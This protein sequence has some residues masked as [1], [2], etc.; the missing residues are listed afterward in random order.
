MAE[1]IGIISGAITF[2][3]VVAQIS[4]S[5]FQIKECWSQIRDAPEELQEL[6]AELEIYD[7]ILRE[8]EQSLSLGPLAN[9][10][11]TSAH[12][13]R[14]LEICKKAAE[15]LQVISNELAKDLSPSSRVRRSYS[16][17]KT[18][19]QKSKVEKY[20][21]KLSNSIRLLSLSQQCYSIALM[22]TQP[23]MG[24][25]IQVQENKSDIAAI[26]LLMISD[27]FQ[28]NKQEPGST[29]DVIDISSQKCTYLWRLGLPIWITSKVFEIQGKRA[30]GGWQWV[31]R[32]YDFLSRGHPVF[33][34][35]AHGDLDGLRQVFSSGKLS[36]FVR[37][38]IGMTLLSRAC[39][40]NRFE[41]AEFLLKQGADP[42]VLDYFR[43]KPIS[44]I[45]RIRINPP[46]KSQPILPLL[47]LLCQFENESQ[48]DPEDVFLRSFH[49]FRGTAE[50]FN[51]LQQA[52]C[53]LF[54]TLSD[55]ERI[56]FAIM[57]LGACLSRNLWNG[58][59]IIRAILNGISFTTSKFEVVSA[60][61]SNFEVPPGIGPFI[62]GAHMI[63]LP[64]GV[65]YCM[66]CTKID[67]NW[68]H[69][70]IKD[71]AMKQKVYEEWYMM[72]R[73]M[74]D[75][76]L[77]IHKAMNGLTLLQA[78]IDGC[79]QVSKPLQ[80][81]LTKKCN[82]ALRALLRDLQGAGVNLKDFG[83]REELIL[84]DQGGY[85]DFRTFGRSWCFVIRLI[86]FSYGPTPE[87]WCLWV[88]EPSDEFVG[89]FWAM[90]D[91]RMEMPG[92]WSED[93]LLSF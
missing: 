8:I 76:G 11:G 13:S 27:Y 36:F 31:F 41:V 73:E 45:G 75:N 56:R 83:E 22:Q 69:D 72:F 38:E 88:S 12:L 32:T 93:I 10:I 60:T 49:R 90:V 42:N 21:A 1:V 84:Q 35:V 78:F 29:S 62:G 16:S 5:I 55:E 39:Y 77:H 17:F 28:E 14:S 6:I 50:E 64:H 54:F 86:G 66:G 63:T 67:S 18:V 85:I 15:R 2:A 20:K 51:F 92:G 79:L 61:L 23:V 82:E 91:R 87:D 47:R 58:P 53:P 70:A 65:A 80:G 52:C 59:S 24:P 7:L 57:E 89:D 81:S 71:R 4:K 44:S 48:E 3:T 9:A 68:P 19:L 25:Q 37:D 33:D 30:Y 43:K 74:L 46:R 40:H 34:F 26:I